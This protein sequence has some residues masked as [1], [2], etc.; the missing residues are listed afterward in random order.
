MSGTT[1]LSAG[2]ADGRAPAFDSGLTIPDFAAC[3]SMGLRPVGLVQGFYCGQIANWANYSARPV[4]N[5]RC[6]CV[7]MNPHQ[8]GWVG[9]VDDLDAGWIA[10]FNAALERMV[11]EAADLGAHGIV[12]VTTEMS[13]PTNRNSAEVHLYGT[14]VVLDGVAAPQRP[15]STQ[16]AGHKLAKLVE[17]GFVPY[18]VAYVRSTAIMVEGCNMEY[19]GSGQCGTGQIIEPLR[20]VHALARSVAISAARASSPGTSLYNVRMQVN[21]AEHMRSTYVTCSILGSSVRQVRA[22]LPVAQPL[23]TVNLRS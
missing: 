19:F 6:A 17:M 11:K 13:H 16:L 18:S 9:R 7:E 12:G 10:A 1:T 22:A 4:Y 14:A 2:T 15:W 23:A 20:D 5:Y 3:L 21:E 8:T